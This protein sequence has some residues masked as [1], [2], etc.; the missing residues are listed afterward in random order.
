ML[1]LCDQS[2]LILRVRTS[3]PYKQ[4]THWSVNLRRSKHSS[5]CIRMLF[6]IL[7]FIIVSNYVLI[8]IPWL[9]SKVMTFDLFYFICYSIK[10]K[11]WN[12]DQC[13]EIIKVLKALKGA[14]L[15]LSKYSQKMIYR[16]SLIN[17]C[18]KNTCITNWLMHV[19]CK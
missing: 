13:R 5:R 1:R 8:S 12:N 16:K 2:P 10:L 9:F 3:R 7:K 17:V 19:C 18:I 15:K 14:A 4:D 11:L 6:W